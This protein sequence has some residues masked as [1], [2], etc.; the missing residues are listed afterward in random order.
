VAAVNP[1]TVVVVNSGGPVVLPWRHDVPAVLLSWFG[2]QAAGAGLADVLFGAA[3]PGGRLP[4]TWPA[5]MADVPVLDTTPVAG[6]LDYAEGPHIGHRAWLRSGV[7]PAYWFGHGLGYTTWSYEHVTVPALSMAGRPFTVYVEV[8]NTGARAGREVVQ[9]YLSRVDTAVERPVRWLAGYAAVT[10]APGE[11]VR[12]AVVVAPRSVEHWA[13]GDW[14][15]EQG[16]FDVLVGRSAAD[17][18]LRGSVTIVAG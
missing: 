9:V 14:H 12:A 11:M 13:A 6:V 7:E 15:V 2:G 3:E 16:T 5:A 18:P 10:A 17:V 4:T 8:R 1:R